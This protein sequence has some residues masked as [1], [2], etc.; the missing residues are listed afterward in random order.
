VPV[1][2]VYFDFAE[3][4]VG[5]DRFIAMSGDADAD[6]ALVQAHLGHRVGKRPE[7][8]APVKWKA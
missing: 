3:R 5:V 4:V 7:Q 2:L 6:M 8:A 1:A